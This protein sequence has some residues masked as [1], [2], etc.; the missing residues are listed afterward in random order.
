M[1]REKFK[2][3]RFF[4]KIFSEKP[5]KS[6]TAMD[7]SPEAGRTENKPIKSTIEKPATTPQRNTPPPSLSYGSWQ[8]HDGSFTDERDIVI[9]FDFGT[10]CTKVVLQDRQ[11]KKAFAV[12]FD[13]IGSPNNHYLIPSKLFIDSNGMITLTPGGLAVSDLK[14]RCV[15]NPEQVLTTENNTRL[16]VTAYDLVAA[17]IALVLIEVQKWFRKT[18]A[19]DYQ[20]IHI[21][22]QLNIG[23]PSHSYDNKILYTMMKRAALT[24]W[25][26]T[27]SSNPDLFVSDIKEADKISHEQLAK[28]DYDENRGQIHPDN[29]NPIPEIIAE[30]IGYANSQLRNNG[31]YLLADVGASTL[32]VSTFILYDREGEDF[33]TIL[34][35]E[36]AKLGAYVLHNYRI[37][38]A[39]KIIEKKLAEVDSACDGI[40]PLPDVSEYIPALTKSD[41]QA[42]D[43]A[44][45]QFLRECSRLLRAVVG[46]TKKRRNPRADEWSQGLPVFLCGG[47]SQVELYQSMIKHAA[48]RL[49]PIGFPG[50]HLKVLPKPDNL[51]GEGIP[52]RDYHRIAVSYGLSYSEI[53]LGHIIPQREVEDFVCEPRFM[54]IDK[55]FVDKD[56]V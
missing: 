18:K 50:F 24:G 20:H 8:L 16:D 51:E 5:A 39:G 31:M 43:D 54:D 23:L 53:D 40:S 38:E 4:R 7:L 36:V 45:R 55:R 17:Y 32:D 33:Y 48:N 1:K 27:V 12:P 41:K 21:A 26:L 30:V 46:E 56:M 34:F 22:W 49:E 3:G 14:L 15:Q 35:A 10:A 9:G 13:T 19:R 28:N 44:N 42:F 47:G 37:K 25:N 6:T 52:P 11:L 29:V 2:I